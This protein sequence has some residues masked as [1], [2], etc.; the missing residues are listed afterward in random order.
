M[1]DTPNSLLMSTD[2]YMQFMQRSTSR[3]IRIHGGVDP[4]VHGSV[5]QVGDV[6][7]LH[8]PDGFTPAHGKISLA[9]MRK[10]PKLSASPIKSTV[11]ESSR[12][13]PES[14][15]GVFLPGSALPVPDVVAQS[16]IKFAAEA[17][18]LAYASGADG[19]KISKIF[20]KMWGMPEEFS[21]EKY[22]PTVDPMKK[23]PWLRYGKESNYQVHYLPEQQAMIDV[24]NGSFTSTTS[25][26]EKQVDWD[27]TRVAIRSIMTCVFFSEP[28]AFGLVDE[29]GI[30]LNFIINMRNF[31]PVYQPKWEWNDKKLKCFVELTQHDKDRLLVERPRTDRDKYRFKPTSQM[32][33][34][35][36]ESVIEELT[37]EQEF[38][39]AKGSLGSMDAIISKA[40][41]SSADFGVILDLTVPKKKIERR[42]MSLWDTFK[43]AFKSWL[44]RVYKVQSD[45]HLLYAHIVEEDYP[46]ARVLAMNVIPGNLLSLAYNAYKQTGRTP[47]LRDSF[48]ALLNVVFGN[49]T[50]FPKFDPSNIMSMV[51]AALATAHD[52]ILYIFRDAYRICL[53][54]SPRL[55]VYDFVRIDDYYKFD[56]VPLDRLKD[57][58]Y[59]TIATWYAQRYYERAKQITFKMKSETDPQKLWK[60]KDKR[61]NLQF[62]Y[63]VYI[64]MGYE[65]QPMSPNEAMKSIVLNYARKRKRKQKLIPLIEGI[66]KTQDVL[67]VAKKLEMLVDIPVLRFCKDSIFKSNETK[68]DVERYFNDEDDEDN[69][70]RS[71]EDPKEA[72]R[73][74]TRQYREKDILTSLASSDFSMEMLPPDEYFFNVDPEAREEKARDLLEVLQ[75]KPPIKL[76]PNPF[77]VLEDDEDTFAGFSSDEE[78]DPVPDLVPIGSKGGKPKQQLYD[79]DED[80][81]AFRQAKEYNESNKMP[82][83]KPSKMEVQDNELE[84]DMSHD[85]PIVP[86]QLDDDIG[87]E[88]QLAIPGDSGPEVF[89]DVDYKAPAKPSVAKGDDFDMLSAFDDDED[90]YGSPLDQIWPWDFLSMKC[91]FYE[92]ST[93]VIA[94]QRH[95]PYVNP[96]QPSTL[97]LMNKALEAITP[98]LKSILEEQRAQLGLSEEVHDDLSEADA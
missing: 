69:Y 38:T 40:E 16:Q 19:S 13:V 39:F 49:E 72:G 78:N 41:L 26:I 57:N 27:R 35:L 3:K 34:G 61:A 60:Y 4:G 84:K 50:K 56:G 90:D 86:S 53:H 29:K 54:H 32:I 79:I 6:N 81:L 2:E 95:A 73:M 63:K 23:K 71:I 76:T 46:A 21:V 20:N 47:Q 22:M 30:Q 96:S 52:Q 43:Y 9:K 64:K 51:G 1:G 62:R 94:L 5:T 91:G 45:I 24:S 58:A 98:H 87:T 8:L 31:E 83:V 37:E 17:A 11:P 67:Q 88:L 44:L 93:I 14:G 75:S 36:P 89:G 74:K 7:K 12:Y 97:T 48:K 55:T 25:A 10:N 66:D 85:K 28:G 77:S 33:A 15:G 92:R 59:V 18:A 70:I 68:K 82:Y 42:K 80:E 65:K